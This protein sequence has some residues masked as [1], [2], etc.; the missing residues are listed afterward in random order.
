MLLLLTIVE[1]TGLM[2]VNGSTGL[3]T[4][5]TLQAFCLLALLEQ[6]VLTDLHWYKRFTVPLI[7]DETTILLAMT[8]LL[9]FP[10]VETGL[11]T[12]VSGG[13]SSSL[14]EK[15][16]AVGK[17]CFLEKLLYNVLRILNK[18]LIWL[19][20]A[21]KVDTIDFASLTF[22]Y[23]TRCR[24]SLYK[25]EQSRDPFGRVYPWSWTIKAK[26]FLWHSYFKK[27]FTLF[28]NNLLTHQH[29]SRGIKPHIIMFTV[30]DFLRKVVSTSTIQSVIPGGE[31]VEILSVPH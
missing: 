16:I 2:A 12:L 15:E 24:E 6:T 5:L 4:L 26:P 31:S 23:S 1:Q 28:I 30:L 14:K 13:K 29:S 11:P 8:W 18:K 21:V 20:C 27:S 25:R 19:F 9:Q 10:N 3:L 7:L 17:D 22:P